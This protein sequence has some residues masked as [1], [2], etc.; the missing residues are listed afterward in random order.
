MKDLIL[1]LQCHAWKKTGHIS[2][3]L[4]IIIS[5]ENTINGAFYYDYYLLFAPLIGSENESISIKMVIKY[6][7]LLCPYEYYN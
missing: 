3:K 2:C 4:V 5:E 6:D 7:M 1:E